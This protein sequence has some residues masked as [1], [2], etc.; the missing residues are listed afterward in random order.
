MKYGL[1]KLSLELKESIRGKE[2]KRTRGRDTKD[3]E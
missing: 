3:M 2:E 1:N